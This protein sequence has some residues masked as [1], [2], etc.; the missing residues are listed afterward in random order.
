VCSPNR[1]TACRAGELTAPVRVTHPFHPLFGQEIDIVMRRRQWSDD[2][3]FYRDRR[4]YLTALPTHWTSMGD[5]DPF[6]IVSAGRSQFRVTD[7]IDLAALI[8]ELQS[9]MQARGGQGEL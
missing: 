5:E 2:L 3:L 4:G 8:T 7:L 6:L 9:P 1:P